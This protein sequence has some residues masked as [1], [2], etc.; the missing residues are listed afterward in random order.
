MPVI[1]SA[2]RAAW[3]CCGITGAA[4]LSLLAF[5][6]WLHVRDSLGGP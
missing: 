1:R 2:R 6:G 5:E 4:V 3:R